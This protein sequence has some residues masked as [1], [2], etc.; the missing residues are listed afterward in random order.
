LWHSD[1]HSPA[2]KHAHTIYHSIRNQYWCSVK[3]QCSTQVFQHR[4]KSSMRS[5]RHIWCVSVCVCV[6]CLWYSHSFSHT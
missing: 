3:L 2:H 5:L 6:V 1:L 4:R